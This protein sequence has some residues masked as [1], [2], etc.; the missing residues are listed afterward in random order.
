MLPLFVIASRHIFS[1]LINS[2][3]EIKTLVSTIFFNSFSVTFVF[4]PDLAV[5][6]VI[7]GI[8]LFISVVFVF[9]ITSL[10]RLVTPGIL[11]SISV[12]FAFRVEVLIN[13]VTLRILQ[14]ISVLFELQTVVWTSPLVLGISL[15]TFSTFSYRP[16][17]SK[18]Y[19][20]LV[21]NSPVLGILVSITLI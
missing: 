8:L 14:S 6:L 19:C 1:N 15:S 13:W 3:V 20:S 4:K 18:S 21:I 17:L 9:K 2:G 7:L 16:C 11:F 10:A 12:T 5:K